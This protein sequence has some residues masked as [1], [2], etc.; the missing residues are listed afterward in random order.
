MEIINQDN[1]EQAR[2]QIDKKAVNKE[3]VV[4]QGRNI[5]FNRLVLENRKVN[6]LILSHI[7]K[8][9]KLK[10]RDSGL[11]QVLCK[12]A[13]DNNITL[14]LDMKELMIDDKKEKANI[15]GRIIQNLKL[16]KKFKNELKILNKPDKRNL[17]ALLQVL[18]ADTKLAS[19]ASS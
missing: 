10:E 8:K 4:V 15:L 5:E 19:E 12:L 6:M 17:Q 9:D 18:G 16:I 14:A 3:K 11:N 1:Y 2:R 7:N 13:R